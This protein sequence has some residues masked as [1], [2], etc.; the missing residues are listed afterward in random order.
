MA[1]SYPTSLDT[2]TNPTAGS[3][4][5]SPSHAQQHSDAND[6]IEALQSKVG[7]DGSNVPYSH[8]YKISQLESLVTSAVAGAKSIYQDVRNNTVSSIAKGTP[9][10][11]SGTE[12]ASGRLFI[13]PSSY[14][15]E[16]TSSKTLGITTSSIASNNN[17]QIISEGVL[18]NVDTTGANDGDPIW[19]GPNGTKIYGLINKPHAPNH[20]VFL[21]VVIRG[22]QQSSGSI[23]VK[24]QNGFELEELHN[25]SL[26]SPTNNQVLRYNIST[27]LWENQTIDN[28]FEPA[29]SIAT[30]E[31]DTTNVHG[32]ADTAQLETKTGAQTKADTAQSNAIS[33]SAAALSAHEAN[34][35]N[36]HGIADTAQLA[37]K[38]YADTSAANAQTA[39]ANALAAHELDTTNIHGIAN[40]ADLAT[41]S[42]ADTV[43]AA[44][45]AAIVDFAPSALNTLNELSAALA[46]DPNFATT[47][48]NALALKAPINSPAF[49]GDVYLPPSTTIGTVSST[50]IGYLDGVT[51]PIQTQL[52]DKA[53]LANPALTGTPTAPTATAGTNT[54]Q[55]AT[56]AFVKTSSDAA[57]QSSN[58]YTDQAVASLGNNTSENYVP[59]SLVGAEDGIATLEGGYVPQS[60]LNI[61]E[62]IQDQAGAL[63][64]HNLHQNIQVT[65]DDENNKIIF[66]A[67][68]QLTQEQV[69]D[70]LAPLFA[71]NSNPNITATY[72][73]VNNKMILEAII[74]PS[75]AIMSAAAPSNPADGELWFDTDEYRTGTVRALKVWNALTSA[76]EYVSSDL[77]LSTTNTWTSK[78]SFNQG[79]I[80]G[81]SAAPSSPIHG[82]IYY[83][84]I[85]DKLKVWDGLLWQDIQGSG[86]GGGLSLV[87]TDTSVP[88][89]TFFVG[90]IPPPEGAIT[91]GD[92]WIDVDDDAGSTEFIF[93]GPNP[94]AEGTYGTDTLWI[95]TD[96]P[97]LPLIYSDNEPP[98]YSAI[99]GDFWVDLDDTS[100]Q[101]ILSSTTPPS[102]E[103]T[104]FWLDL[105]TEEGYLTY[106]D[107]FKN[108]AAQVVNKESLPSASNY[109]GMIAYVTSE[110]SLYVAAGGIWI[111]IF[112]TYDAETLIWSGI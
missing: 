62:R 68:A 5:A 63:I 41:K 32:I 11:I 24:I 74:P 95:D 4:V 76:W 72:D 16:S 91:E 21:G 110:N 59:I 104:E 78:N 23:F 86:G 82:Q 29:G 3:S 80:I 35:T 103:Q 26:T 8:D 70:L 30:H 9:V 64:Q 107:L 77:S 65:Y 92:L 105:T 73:D 54:T 1:I 57:V 97:D 40:T 42:Y 83:N 28:L 22:G 18:T 99:E 49:S 96:D 25:V 13:S 71:H 81:L 48:T 102:P 53:P 43:A 15:A 112:P 75:T 14:S 38:S 7:V 87:P 6:A 39:A 90:L 56:T 33:T 67:L 37:T 47:I 84:T 27:G 51:S 12:G 34:T 79:V 45:A 108:N 101:S 2:L 58:S 19:L 31:A 69:Q 46:N 44:A 60:Q 106:A 85:L 50:E 52:N 20:L 100:G 10:Y 89:S 88:A 94:P 111:K 17:G 66:T 98:S 61:D 93:A 55:I 36:I 109:G